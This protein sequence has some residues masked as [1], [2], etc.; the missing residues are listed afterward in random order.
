MR[1]LPFA[2]VRHPATLFLPSI[3]ACLATKPVR[4][5][6][7]SCRVKLKHVLYIKTRCAR[8]SAGSALGQSN[9]CSLRRMSSTGQV[10]RTERPV[11][12]KPEETNK[13]YTVTGPAPEQGGRRT[14]HLISLIAL[15]PPMLQRR[16]R[17]SH[18]CFAKF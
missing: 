12:R 18:I 15:I 9:A 14:T 13:T 1:F 16:V 2:L 6:K 7:P 8:T 11:T 5:T 17:G 3:G 4:T 10:A